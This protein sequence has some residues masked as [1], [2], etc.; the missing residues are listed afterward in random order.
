MLLLEEHSCR[1]SSQ[2]DFNRPSLSLILKS[3]P[4]QEEQK[5]DDD[6]E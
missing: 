1:T 4:Q 3:S 6:D 5:E 2:C